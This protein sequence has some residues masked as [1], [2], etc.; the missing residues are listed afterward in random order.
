ML[1]S[2]EM[3]FLVKRYIH[4]VLLVAKGGR[5]TARRPCALQT[6][7]GD[8]RLHDH[9]ILVIEGGCYPQYIGAETPGRAVVIAAV[10]QP[11]DLILVVAGVPDRGNIQVVGA[12]PI[13]QLNVAATLSLPRLKTRLNCADVTAIADVGASGWVNLVRDLCLS[14]PQRLPSNHLDCI[15]MGV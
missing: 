13:I 3:P 9:A 4:D 8:V 12:S 6:V 7:E 14:P 15:S 5:N 10:F 1:H 11:N 2:N